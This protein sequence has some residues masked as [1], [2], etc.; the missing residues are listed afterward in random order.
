M[1][2]VTKFI[3]IFIIVAA[4]IFLIIAFFLPFL[5]LTGAIF[6]G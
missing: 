2:S 4:A 1:N 3:A 6:G 5:V